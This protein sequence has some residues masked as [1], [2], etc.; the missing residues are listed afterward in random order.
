MLVDDRVCRAMREMRAPIVAKPAPELEHALDR[1]R[2]K[3]RD[4]GK[5]G[6]EAQVVR[7]HRR[8]LRLL[9]HDLGK[10]DAV[11]IARMLPRQAAPS[12][13]LLPRDEARCERS[14]QG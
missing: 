7:N 4:I 2:G 10:P 6:K 8:N 14:R 1:C 12:V 13:L 3:A 5:S 11:R 9:Q